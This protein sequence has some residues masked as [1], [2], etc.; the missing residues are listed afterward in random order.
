MKTARTAI[1]LFA[2]AAAAPLGGCAAQLRGWQETP[3]PTHDRQR[4]F[5]AAKA[6][7]GR[8]FE[9]A[10]ANWT[11]GVIE[12]EPKVF[13]GRH[14]ETLADLRGAETRWRRT[15]TCEIGRDG[16]TV[17]ARMVVRLQREGT[18]QA[19]VLSVHGDERA[20]RQ[21]PESSPPG[22]MPG[23]ARPQEVWTDVGYDEAFARTLLAEISQQVQRAESREAPPPGATPEEVF[24]ESYEVGR[25]AGY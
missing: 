4:A 5:N 12:T 24:E 25:D 20:Y 13:E 17:T 23:A 22:T 9:V 15:A 18:D 2:V 16:L 8:H 11:R 6:V 7:L 14:G 19:A 21:V 10:E 3:L 1:L